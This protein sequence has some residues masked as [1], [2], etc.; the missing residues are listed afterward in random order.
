MN[1]LPAPQ[2]KENALKLEK[3]KQWLKNVK[4]WLKKQQQQ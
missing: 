3:L 2:N 1:L 4:K